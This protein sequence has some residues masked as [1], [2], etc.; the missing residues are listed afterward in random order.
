MVCL[1]VPPLRERPGDVHLLAEHFLERYAAEYGREITRFSGPALQAI[2]GN[3][4]PGNVRELENA[5]ERAV[6]LAGESGVVTPEALGLSGAMPSASLETREPLSSPESP[7]DGPILPL[8]VALEGPERQLILRALEANHGNR[9]QTAAMLGVNRTTLFNKM[10][11]YGL[12]DI[13]S[14]PPKH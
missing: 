12:L 11:K 5:I 4:W 7:D 13:P 14:S 2:L 3:D 6:L 10:K 9:N 1:E 8:R